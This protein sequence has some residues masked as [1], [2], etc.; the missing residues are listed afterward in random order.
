M[1]AEYLSSLAVE[2]AFSK[3]HNDHLRGRYDCR[4]VNASLRQAY[5]D[6]YHSRYDYH[7]VM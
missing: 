3:G 5:N 4:F 1:Q 6:G 2:R 7:H